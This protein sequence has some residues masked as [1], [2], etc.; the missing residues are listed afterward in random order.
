MPE[1]FV[2]CTYGK[3][4]GRKMLNISGPVLKLY[5]RICTYLLSQKLTDP[6]VQSRGYIED[7]RSTDE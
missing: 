1:I 5:H 7:N 4:G 3:H 6:E 2:I